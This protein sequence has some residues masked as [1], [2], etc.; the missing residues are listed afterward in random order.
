MEIYLLFNSQ[1]AVVNLTISLAF[2]E[3]NVKIEIKLLAL[4]QYFF[5]QQ[6]GPLVLQHRYETG[7]NKIFYILKSIVQNRNNTRQ[8]HPR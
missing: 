6:N 8:F 3:S 1:A 7:T 2:S 4:I 5:F